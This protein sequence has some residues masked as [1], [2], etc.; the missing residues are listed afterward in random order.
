M[1]DLIKKILNEELTK[2]LTPEVI[3]LFK[4][5]QSK[6]KELKT[7]KS[8]IEFLEKRLKMIGKHSK[9]AQKY[10]YLYT[11]NYREN[12]DYENIKPE[13]FFNEKN[14]P[15]LKVTNVT[16]GKYAYAKMPFEGS[17]VRGYWEKD[18]NG[19]EQYVIKSYGWYP[20][21]VFKNGKWYSVSERYSNSTS[22]QY[23]NV[24]RDGIYDTTTLRSKDLKNLVFGYDE[25]KIKNS[26]INEFMEDYKDNFLNSSF[27]SFMALV[28]DNDYTKI[29]FDCK[30]INV[31]LSG[32]KIIIDAEVSPKKVHKHYNF[33]DENKK[34]VENMFASEVFVKTKIL[35]PEDV[36]I[37][38]KFVD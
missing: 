19:V 27:Y 26:R 11:L 22:K 5:I 1:K 18:R 10:Y 21:L 14:F 15:A 34:E 13:E 16:A 9:E 32:E 23:N 7:K 31:E 6:K 35:N 12:G 17:N 33:S 4:L 28:I 30:I 3:L 37:N 36:K 20:I 8:I 2:K 38:V 29:S 24:T 25:E